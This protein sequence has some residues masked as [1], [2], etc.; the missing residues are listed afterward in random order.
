MVYD[1]SLIYYFKNSYQKKKKKKN[2]PKPT[3]QTKKWTWQESAN[4]EA[5]PDVWDV[6]RLQVACTVPFDSKVWPCYH[7]DSLILVLEFCQV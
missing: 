6:W 3:N 7:I 5:A 1:I 2:P 4:F